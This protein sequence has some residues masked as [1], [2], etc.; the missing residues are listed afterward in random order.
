MLYLNKLLLKPCVLI[1]TPKVRKCHVQA[2]LLPKSFA[3]ISV[4]E[5]G[6]FYVWRNRFISISQTCEQL[7]KA[8]HLNLNL[9]FR[10]DTACNHPKIEGLKIYEFR[11]EREKRAWNVNDCY[12]QFLAT[13]KKEK[14]STGW[15]LSKCPNIDRNP[16]INWKRLK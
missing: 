12:S 5:A 15:R 16:N 4:Y 11:D 3:L 10:S 1:L 6:K 13:I 7:R 2:K 9:S 8:L 14:T